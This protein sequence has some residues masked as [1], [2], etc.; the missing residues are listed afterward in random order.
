MGRNSCHRPDETKRIDS[1]AIR[2]SSP[3]IAPTA[4]PPPHRNRQQA[5]ILKDP[6]RK[7]VRFAEIAGGK[8][9]ECAA[10][11]CC[12][13]CGLANLFFLAAVRLPA[14]LCCRAVQKRIL[15]RR[16]KKKAEI[17]ESGSGSN[18]GCSSGSSKSGSV[19]DDGFV[20]FTG[21]QGS[22]MMVIGNTWPARSPTSEVVEFEKEVWSKFCGRGFW[23]SLSQ[24]DD[25]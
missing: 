6:K 5:A 19:T 4:P 21:T 9:A 25:L 24:K 11:F 22:V 14:G 18:S 1:S 17:L 16:A 15:T 2:I 7:N 20:E 13:P 12:C 23:R 3:A 10:I 8:M